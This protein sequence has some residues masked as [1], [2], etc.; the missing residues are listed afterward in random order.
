MASRSARS[1]LYSSGS[2]AAAAYIREPG[3]T[4]WTV[5]SSELPISW[6]EAEQYLAEQ[7]SS[8]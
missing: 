2:R 3:F 7:A 5:L 6:A 1:Q 4:F 8:Y